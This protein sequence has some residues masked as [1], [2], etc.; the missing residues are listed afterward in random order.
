VLW[1]SQFRAPVA[2][3]GK[4][5]PFH[6]TA[7]AVGVNMGYLDLYLS[8]ECPLSSARVTWIAIDSDIEDVASGNITVP[9]QYGKIRSGRIAFPKGVFDSPPKVFIGPSELN[10]EK[11]SDLQFACSATDITDEDFEYTFESWGDSTYKKA[12]LHWIAVP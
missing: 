3:T 11:N 4:D 7:E 1:I 6:I 12:T 9:G 10:W 5:F 2:S 8:A